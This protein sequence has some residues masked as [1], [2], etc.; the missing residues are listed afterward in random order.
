MKKTL[1]RVFTLACLTLLTQSLFAQNSL[2]P[3]PQSLQPN[4]QR[5]NPPTPPQ[6][7]AAGSRAWCYNGSGPFQLNSQFLSNTTVTPIGATASYGFPGAATWVASANLMYVVD[8]VSPFPLYTVDTTT[9][10]R[11]FI[12]NCTGITLSNM[13]GMAWDPSTNTMF[14]MQSSIS[15][16]QLMT[17]N[18]T[19]GVCTP[20]GAVST[21]SPGA[22][23]LSCTSHGSLFSMD[24]VTDQLHR[25]NRTTGVATVVGPLGFDANYGQDAQFDHTDD[26]LYGAVFNN[27]AFAP[28]LR[29]IDTLTGAATFIGTYTGTIQVQTLAIR[30]VCSPTTFSQSFTGCS[31]FSVTVGSNTY[32]ASGVYTDHF[33]N[34]RGCDSTVTTTLTVNPLPTVG[35]MTTA[36]AV[37]AGSPVTLSGTGATS[38]SWSGGVTDNVAFT[39]TLTDSYTVTGTD[40]NGCS[41]T[42]VISVTVNAL[43]SVSA[44]STA[45]AVCSGGQVTLTGS[46]ATNYTWTGN[47]TDN[48]AFTPASTDTYTVTGTDGN[49]CSNTASVMVTVNA[50]PSVSANTTAAAVCTGDS[51]TLTGSG[52]TSYVWTGNVTD[53]VAFSPATTDTYTVTGT[54]GN[55]CS[56][57]DEVTVTVNA[58]P[59]VTVALTMD[60]LCQSVGTI[61]LAGE[62]PAGGTWSGSGVS[63]NTFDPMTSGT[64]NIM[65]DYMFTDANGC[66]ASAT[67]SIW[68]DVCL[69]VTSASVNGGVSVFPNPTSGVFTVQAAAGSTVEIMNEL[70]QTVKSFTMTANQSEVNMNA[71]ESG[72]YF[73]RTINGEAVNVTRFV[74]Q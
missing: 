50:L 55:G 16:S 30:P 68:V 44:A 72:V 53:S 17:I 59:V 22:I 27:T 57:S 31:P 63:G 3:A 9:G 6:V 65:I 23:S 48:V 46:G 19:T 21:V 61:T 60:T 54:D 5:N 15:Q 58:L 42:A 1:T 73:L 20:I 66:S 35:T 49:G 51:V 28:E 40:G 70:G 64:G 37:C 62:S 71:Y 32:T 8:Q 25:W 2:G 26:V 39:P 47:V 11:T 34:A 52:A 24:I 18:L 14:G 41:N 67:D 74:K 36:S 13:T 43:P 56:N 45:S 29:S 4:A 7:L 33:T 10:V 38:Y 12:A 69:D